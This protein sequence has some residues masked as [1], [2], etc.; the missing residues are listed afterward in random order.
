MIYNII[1]FNLKLAKNINKFFLINKNNYLT[2]IIFNYSYIEKYLD[3][4]LVYKD[5]THLYTIYFH[6]LLYSNIF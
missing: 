1:F 6:K 3:F 2:D 5:Y 4:L